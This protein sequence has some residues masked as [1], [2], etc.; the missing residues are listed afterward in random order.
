M[1]RVLDTEFTAMLSSQLAG[2]KEQQEG[3]LQLVFLASCQTAT[4]SPADA[5]RGF[6]PS[7]VAAGVPAVL[8]MQDLVP[9][10]TAQAFTQTF[11]RQLFQHGL[12]DLA[13]NEA[14]SA[15]VSA[16][17]PG[18]AIPVL[19]SRSDGNRLL[20]FLESDVRRPAI[21]LAPFEPQTV[22][23]PAGTFLMGSVPGSGVPGNETP[24]H[25]V[26]LPAYRIGMYL[27][28]VPM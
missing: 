14:R 12:V 20:A 7:L 22:L 25:E 17:L 23:I 6:A 1:M 18:A 24:Q 13:C 2:V 8:A 21:E 16:K 4:R 9:V 28:S 15:L 5:F 10:I 11:Y 26:T 3:G 19:L 27:V